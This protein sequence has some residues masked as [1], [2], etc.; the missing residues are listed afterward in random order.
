MQ[1]LNVSPSVPA[2]A[3]QDLPVANNVAGPSQEPSPSDPPFSPELFRPLPAE[4]TTPGHPASSS[5]SSGRQVPTLTHIPNLVSISTG[6][7]SMSSSASNVARRSQRA[8]SDAAPRMIRKR[9]KKNTQTGSD[10]GEHDIMRLIQI[11]MLARM[12]SEEEDKKRREEENME[13]RRQEEQLKEERR[14]EEQEKKLQKQEEK[15]ERRREMEMKHERDMMM[16]QREQQQQQMMMMMMMQNLHRPPHD[17]PA[18][19][20]LTNFR[21]DFNFTPSPEEEKDESRS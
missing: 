20:A 10:K 15:E 2:P 5:L 9:A 12:E 4:Q 21:R 17:A 14:R 11:K 16:M 18:S 3:N 7:A 19:T 13:R 6:N 8:L 1:N